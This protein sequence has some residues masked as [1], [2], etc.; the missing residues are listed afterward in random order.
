MKCLIPLL[1]LSL[2]ACCV[3]PKQTGPR[4][5]AVA[6][7]EITGIHAPYVAEAKKY[8]NQLA[9]ENNFTVDFIVNSDPI[10]DEFLS[11]YQVF[12]ELNYPPYGW[13]PTAAAA[14]EKYIE[15]GRGGWVGFH[16]ASLVGEFDGYPTWEWFR[17]FIGG[18]KWKAYIPTFARANVIVE[19]P[20]HPVMKGVPPSFIV[21]LE[22]WYTYD[23]DPRPNVRVLARVDESSYVPDSKTKMGDH[24]VIWSNE[25]YKARN[26][27]VFMGHSPVLFQ[28]EEYKTIFRNAILWAAGVNN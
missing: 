3:T 21:K 28:S 2:T 18:I 6:M 4:F 26:V 17:Q 22:E 13:K 9:A 16:H 5:H 24:P 15:K 19:D 14:F 1:L 7:A 25:H 12:I 27:Y 8:L 11:K 23:Q 10:D 20:T